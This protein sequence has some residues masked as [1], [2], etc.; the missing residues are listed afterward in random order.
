MAVETYLRLRIHE[1]DDPIDLQR[2]ISD[3]AGYIGSYVVEVEA[4]DGDFEPFDIIAGFN[5]RNSA[6]VDDAVA[7][8]A[9]VVDVVFEFRNRNDVPPSIG[10][11]GH[12]PT[13]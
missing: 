7:Q 5:G 4:V 6:D 1:G 8:V 2:Q 3:F 12:S 10:G 11:P 13:P 9:E